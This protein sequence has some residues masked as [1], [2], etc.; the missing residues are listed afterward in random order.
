M[1]VKELINLLNEC[2][3]ESDAFISMDVSTS[4]EDADHRF[5][6][7]VIEVINNDPT[8]VPILCEK[9]EQNFND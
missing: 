1:K 8:G 2:D 7:D 9:T 6:G 5:F 4:S 3:P